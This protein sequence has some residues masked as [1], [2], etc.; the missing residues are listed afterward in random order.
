MKIV[1]HNIQYGS[2]TRSYLEYL[3]FWR[4]LRERQG[5]LKRLKK[6]YWLSDIIGLI[7]VDSG[8]FRSFGNQGRRLCNMLGYNSLIQ[9]CKYNGF[10]S[11]IPI[12][13]NQTNALVSR[14]YFE[15]TG[16]FL[17]R[18][19]MKSKVLYG[20]QNGMT[21]F[22][23]HLDLNPVTRRKQIDELSSKL[24]RFKGRKV[25]MG[26]FNCSLSE[27]DVL[28]EE[29]S[30]KSAFEAKTFP[31][32]NAREQRDYVLISRSINVREFRILDEVLSDH[33]AVMVDLIV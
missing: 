28:L 20:K 9:K 15:K 10:L 11:K 3:F 33:K 6:A 16:Y 26:D 31:A 25:I 23:L 22:V 5:V 27:L 12:F 32:W 1:C 29:N 17:L 30:M 24:S 19:G 13:A 4:L 14:E 8:S 21:F 2:C 7:E 18:N